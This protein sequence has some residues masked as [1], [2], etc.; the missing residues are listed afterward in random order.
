MKRIRILLT[1]MFFAASLGLP[2][3]AV[4]QGM[5]VDFSR[6]ERYEMEAQ[7]GSRQAATYE[8]LI[9][10]ERQRIRLLIEKEVNA[11]VQPA[12]SEKDLEPAKAIDSQRKVVDDLSGR[13]NEATVDLNLLKDEE[14]VYTTG[15]TTGT[16]A[17][18]GRFMLTKSFPELLARK[19]VLEEE[20]D[21]FSNALSA[22]QTRLSKLLS[23]QRAASFGMLYTILWYLAIVVFVVWAETLVRTQLLYRIPH[24][25]LRYA[26][27][28]VFTV[29]VYLSLLF[30]LVQRIFLEN[31]GLTTV[32]AVIGAALVFML[33]DVI[34]SFLGWLTY[35]GALKLGQRVTIGDY[36]GDILDIGVLFT[37]MLVSRSPEMKDVSE[38]GKVVR[39]PN[40]QFLVGPLTNFNSTSDFENV[41]IPVRIADP[42]Q[43]KRAQELLEEILVEEAQRF[44]EQARNQMD[45][46]MRGFYFSQV[47]PACRVYMELNEK[48]HLTFL[49]CFP[50]PIGQRRAVVTRILQQVLAKFE[51]NSIKLADPE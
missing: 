19:V 29:V 9:S 1:G 32:L 50:A 21:L 2:V 24:R 4:A 34:K 7:K 18:D 10:A 17:I 48:A 20:I 41:E 13:L 40:A 30:W 25:G 5:S 44:A 42:T 38:A 28:K 23:E 31:P 12:E 39:I 43:S 47:S 22:Q 16:G 49:L 8:P 36:T 35:K 26:L 33:Q 51:E 37:T 3:A 45:R 15:G 11:L 14:K 6:L 27:G 46:R